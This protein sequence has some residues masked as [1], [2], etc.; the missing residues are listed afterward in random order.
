MLQ[1]A[2]VHTNELE[3]LKC[4]PT[5]AGQAAW[6]AQEPQLCNCYI[7]SSRSICSSKAGGSE[8]RDAARDWIMEQA[9]LASPAG[10]QGLRVVTTQIV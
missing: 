9:I 5:R 8:L 2:P 7:K 3:L 1:E 6:L 4:C 10:M